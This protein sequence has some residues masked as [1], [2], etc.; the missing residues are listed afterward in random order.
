M[1]NGFLKYF[2]ITFFMS[3]TFTKSSFAGFIGFTY[4]DLKDYIVDTKYD[5]Q[6]DTKSHSTKF[7]SALTKGSLGAFDDFF[8]NFSNFLNC[9]ANSYGPIASAYG[10]NKANNR[11]LFRC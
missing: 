3:I 2:V 1:K 6:Y 8:Y 10:F 11:L 7:S 4:G 5:V 9:H